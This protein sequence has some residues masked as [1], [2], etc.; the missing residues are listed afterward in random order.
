VKVVTARAHD[1]DQRALLDLAD[2]VKAK[3]GDAAVV[4][5]GTRD[6]RVAIVASLTPG[7]IERGLS[8][9]QIVREAAQVIGGGGGG[10]DDAAQAGGREPERLDEALETARQ[11]IERGL[12]A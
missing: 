2:R 12:G 4:L 7:A 11:A 8:A 3:L 10:R 1:G 6:G 9:A 5:G